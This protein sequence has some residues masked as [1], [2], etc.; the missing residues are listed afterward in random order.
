MVLQWARLNMHIIDVQN[1]RNKCSE[2]HTPI[3]TKLSQTKGL[4][5]GG[6]K[7][8]RSASKRFQCLESKTFRHYATSKS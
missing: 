2:K 6:Y 7:E 3:V 4:G 8:A 5:R 1:V